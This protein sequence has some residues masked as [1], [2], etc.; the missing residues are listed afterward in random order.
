MTDHTVRDHTS[1]LIRCKGFGRNPAHNQVVEAGPGVSLEAGTPMLDA[2]D[3]ASAQGWE[4]VSSY[5]IGN[6]G[7]LT[8][9]LARGR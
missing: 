1:V 3:Q 9:I 4:L 8:L 7:H 5:N 6:D 2:L